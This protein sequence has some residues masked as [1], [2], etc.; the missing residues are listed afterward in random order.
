MSGW[1]IAGI[2]SGGLR[3]AV[4]LCCVMPLLPWVLGAL[5]ASGLLSVLYRDIVLLPF[6]GVMFLAMI[7]FLSRVR[8]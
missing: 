1:R 8:A 6:A 4:L 3:L 5:G 2:G 7:L